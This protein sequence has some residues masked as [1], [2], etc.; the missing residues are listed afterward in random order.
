MNPDQFRDNLLRSFREGAS[1]VEVK[2]REL[3]LYFPE[4]ESFWA[5]LKANKLHVHINPEEWGDV[6]ALSVDAVDPWGPSSG[7]GCPR[8]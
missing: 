7:P 8:L 1:T 6:V 3:E 4:K 2:K 5:F